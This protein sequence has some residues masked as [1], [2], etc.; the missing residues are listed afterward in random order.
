MDIGTSYTSLP[1]RYSLCASTYCARMIASTFSTCVASSR[2]RIASTDPHSVGL[3][4]AWVAARADR[5][6][7]RVQAMVALR[8]E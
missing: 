7:M 3:A 4:P 6:A 1:G 5:R 2:P 8:H